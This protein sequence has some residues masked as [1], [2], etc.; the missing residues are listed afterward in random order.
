MSHSL[1]VVVIYA[2]HQYV[3]IYVCMGLWIK[4]LKKSSAYKLI[5]IGNSKEWGKHRER[6]VGNNNSRFS[7]HFHLMTLHSSGLNSLLSLSA[8]T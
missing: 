3:D 8:C 6:G 1:C 4:V 7:M 5:R 2:I